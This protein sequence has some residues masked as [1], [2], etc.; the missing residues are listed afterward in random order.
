MTND[1]DNNTE[2]EYPEDMWDGHIEELERIQEFV[3]DETTFN[4]LLS[5]T[6]DGN[7]DSEESHRDFT[8]V[9]SDYLGIEYEPTEEEAKW[10]HDT[11][12]WESDREAG[13]C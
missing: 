5:M 10:D 2:I 1:N 3:T 11:A 6:D 12:Q 13:Y 8:K 4:Q 9:I 7:F